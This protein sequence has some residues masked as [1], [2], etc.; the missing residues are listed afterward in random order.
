MS[1][2]H[3]AHVFGTVTPAGGALIADVDLGV[4]NWF[5]KQG[6][7]CKGDAQ[8][9]ESL[10][11]PRLWHIRTSA[12]TVVRIAGGV[13]GPLDPAQ[14]SPSNVPAGAQLGGSGF[15][16]A[17]WSLQTDT[18]FKQFLMDIGEDLEFYGTGAS[19]IRLLAPTGFVLVTPQNQLTA[20]ASAGVVLDTRI[21]AEVVPIETPIGRSRVRFTQQVAVAAGAQADIDVP[22][23]AKAVTVYQTPAGAASVTWDRQIG[24]GATGTNVGTLSFT[25]RTS[26][27]EDTAI[28]DETVL[29]TDLDALAARLFTLIWEIEP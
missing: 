22:R 1:Q 7:A 15:L 2:S 18:G 20:V 11:G 10:R 19:M 3:T 9:E 24:A 28:G 5:G 27:L 23:F 29:R 17:E 14:I 13:V 4:G 12:A 21:G 8:Y 6:P 25:G 16:K 26:R